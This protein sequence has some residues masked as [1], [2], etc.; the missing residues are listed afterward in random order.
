MPLFLL[1]IA[2]GTLSALGTYAFTADGQL[3]AIVGAVCAVLTWLGLA[4]FAVL[5]D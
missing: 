5:D 3:A 4:T 2:L 1:G